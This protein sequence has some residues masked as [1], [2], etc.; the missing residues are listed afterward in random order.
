MTQMR[1]DVRNSSDVERGNGHIVGFMPK[2]VGIKRSSYPA[3]RRSGAS[4]RPAASHRRRRAQA[5]HT[6][7]RVPGAEPA[8]AVGGRRPR[9]ERNPGLVPVDEA[10]VLSETSELLGGSL[11]GRLAIRLAR[12]LAGETVQQPRRAREKRDAQH[13][14]DR[15]ETLA[16]ERQR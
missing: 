5:T 11:R 13:V 10:G 2:L 16:D 1:V 9:I 8:H 6:L 4:R 14:R 3:P 15:G 7:T 12:D